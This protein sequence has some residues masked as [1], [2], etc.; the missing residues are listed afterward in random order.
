[1][2]QGV[3]LSLSRSLSL[4]VPRLSGL[5]TLG[6]QSPAIVNII[7]VNSIAIVKSRVLYGFS[8]LITLR[9]IACAAF[10]HIA[11]TPLLLT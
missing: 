11:T 6:V 4:S 8:E 2:Q 10:L 3:T 9:E 7:V 1:M 5:D